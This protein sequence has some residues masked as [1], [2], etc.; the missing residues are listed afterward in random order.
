MVQEE[1][2]LRRIHEKLFT[3]RSTT[4]GSYPQ[5]K[6]KYIHVKREREKISLIK[7]FF[8]EGFCSSPYENEK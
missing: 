7:G 8:F 6:H 2:W 1:E 4:A 5:E 3:V